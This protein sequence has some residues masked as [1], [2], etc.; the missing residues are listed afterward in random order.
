[1]QKYL[2]GRERA[3]KKRGRRRN[4]RTG[5]FRLLRSTASPDPRFV[6][7]RQTR[8]SRFPG[9]PRLVLAVLSREDRAT[10]L[11]ADNPFYSKRFAY[12]V[13]RRCRNST[14]KAIAEELHLD[15]N[16][17]AQGGTRSAGPNRLRQV[18]RAATSAGCLGR[19]AEERVRASDG[20]GTSF[21]QEV[22]LA[23]PMEKPF[24]QGAAE[25][26]AVVS[27]EPAIR[28]PAPPPP[29]ANVTT[30]RSP[31]TTDVVGDC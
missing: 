2:D 18:P 13:G 21:H 19:R 27:G 15:W 7:R 16:V 26:E 12:Y 25:P 30:S 14:V 8:L 4:L 10:R 24:P 28:P 22:C 31:R 11:A 23:R 9:A 17:H 5:A 6:V 20:A 1:M 29:N 3:E